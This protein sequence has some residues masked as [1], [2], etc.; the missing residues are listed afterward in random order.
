MGFRGTQLKSGQVVFFM[1]S[2]S[3]I[4]L[5]KCVIVFFKLSR[6]QTKICSSLSSA[7]QVNKIK[8]TKS[9]NNKKMN[10]VSAKHVI[11]PSEWNTWKKTCWLW[12]LTKFSTATTL[13]KVITEIALIL[14]SLLSVLK[15][16]RIFYNCCDP[17]HI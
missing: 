6:F 14:F 11:I 1:V 15:T 9:N 4:S 10:L 8:Q 13:V 17:L 2:L 16:C 5:L 3:W 7:S 12:S